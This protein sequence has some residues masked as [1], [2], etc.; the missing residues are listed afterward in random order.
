MASFI[1]NFRQNYRRIIYF[2]LPSIYF[3]IGNLLSF[4]LVLTA[5]F[6]LL[7]KSKLQYF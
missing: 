6:F 1:Y 5:N 2:S 7:E 3:F 4:Q